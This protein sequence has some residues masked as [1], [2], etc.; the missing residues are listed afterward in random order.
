VVED[1]GC[2]IWIKQCEIYIDHL[3]F[4]EEDN[5]NIFWLT[6]LCNCSDALLV[7]MHRKRL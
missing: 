3:Y 4:L 2:H 5:R 6:S 7:G 1:F